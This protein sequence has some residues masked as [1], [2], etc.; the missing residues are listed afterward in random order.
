MNKQ[1]QNLYRA[2][3]ILNSLLIPVFILSFIEI[4]NLSFLPTFGFILIFLIKVSLKIYVMSAVGGGILKIISGEEFVFRIKQAHGNVKDFWQG[5]LIVF[6]IIFLVDLFLLALFHSSFQVWRPLFFSLSVAIATYVLAR[7]FINK[8]Y[9]VP[10]GFPQR[11]FKFKLSFWGVMISACLLELILVRILD[12]IHIRHFHLHNLLAFLQSY[13]HVFEFIYCSLAITENYPEIVEEFNSSPEVFLINPMGGEIVQSLGFLLSRRCP[14]IFVVLKALTPKQ[15]GFHEFNQ[16][17]WHERYYKNNVLVC[18]TCFTSNCYEAYKIAKEFKKRGSKVVMGGPHVTY[19][20]LEAL[21]FCDSVV[22]GQVEGVWGEV[23]RDYENGTLKPQYKGFAT[24]ADYFKIH[25]E[26][27]ASPPSIIEA[28][29]E[30]TRGC[31][32][33]CHFCTIP[34]LMGGQVYLKAINEIIDLIKKIKPHCRNLIFIDNNIYTDPAYARELFI[35]LKPLE[36]RWQS[37]CTIDIAKNQEVLKLAKESGCTLLMFGY[38]IFGKSCEKNQGGKF[39]MAQK[40]IEYTQ[41]I[42]NA[43]IQVRGQFIFGFDSD[44]LKTLFQLWQFC[45]SIMPQYTVISL[46]TPFPGSGL[47]QDM[48]NQNRIISLNWRSYSGTKLVVRHPHL[49]SALISLSFYTVQTF[50]FL[51][52][53]LGGLRLLV[54]CYAIPLWIVLSTFR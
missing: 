36:I 26:L 47:Y 43:G 28:F 12:F 33:R 53:S 52:T 40:Y 25:Q 1:Y 16:V 5:L 14:P 50:F 24:E 15:Y 42:K 41:I 21:V 19:F 10:L 11:A 9:I 27:L 22:I 44:S 23:I 49:D 6:I 31:K 35:A 29:L 54:F 45:F 18:I 17:L 4:L 2:L 46:L 20:P 48:L 34:D 37:A 13:I 30:T 3:S 8:K 7:W 39:A 38:E 32:F 51:T